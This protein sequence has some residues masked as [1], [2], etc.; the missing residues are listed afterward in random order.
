MKFDRN[1]KIS[2][3]R[4]Y[5]IPQSITLNGEDAICHIERKVVAMVADAEEQVVIEAILDM[6][7]AN[8][9]TDLIVLDEEK[10]KGI[11]ERHVPKQPLYIDGD[12]GLPLC[13]CCC[14]ALDEADEDNYCS[15][16]AQAIDWSQNK[17]G[18]AVNDDA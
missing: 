3:G 4:K 9:I 2:L 18:G 7:K 16:C 5:V 1:N 10:I 17:E 6:A 13:P 11:F 15:V 8:G 12:Y 14:L